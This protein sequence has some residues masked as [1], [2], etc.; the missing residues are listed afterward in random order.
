MGT[1]VVLPFG[2]EEVVGAV[3][4]IASDFGSFLFPYHASVR[5]MGGGGHIISVQEIDQVPWY[6]VQEPVQ[7]VSVGR[8]PAYPNGEGG[9]TI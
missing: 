9:G 4:L 8:L 1:F 7:V 5:A 6:L 3:C 2:A